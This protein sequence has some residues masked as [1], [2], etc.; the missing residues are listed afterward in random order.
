M[1]KPKKTKGTAPK[2]SPRHA[3][4][5]LRKLLFQELDAPDQLA[6]EI[7]ASITALKHGNLDALSQLP[8]MKTKALRLAAL[9]D[10]VGAAVTEAA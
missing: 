9:L 1:A 8:A 4:A 7:S 10:K 3:A 5:E 2:T 6:R